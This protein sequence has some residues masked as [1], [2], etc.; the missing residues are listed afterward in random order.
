MGFDYLTFSP[1]CCPGQLF[2]DSSEDNDR[3]KDWNKIDRIQNLKETNIYFRG[4]DQSVELRTI[5][6][7]TTY[8]T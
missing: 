1:K 4:L 7:R 8:T 6:Q 2:K 5:K 3:K